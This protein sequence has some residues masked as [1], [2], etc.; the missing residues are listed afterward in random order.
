MPCVPSRQI[1]EF[2]LKKEKGEKERADAAAEAMELC[3][4]AEGQ[5]AVEGAQEWAAAKLGDDATEEGIEE[6]LD[7][8]NLMHELSR[9]IQRANAAERQAGGTL[10]DLEQDLARDDKRYKKDSNHFHAVVEAMGA[11]QRGI[12]LR[13][14]S[15][16]KLDRNTEANVQSRFK[17]YMSLKVGCGRWENHAPPRCLLPP[18]P[19]P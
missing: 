3:D 15:L 1:E 19:S 13:R 18:W 5:A 4:E 16:K 11:V 2:R 7:S 10:E 9:M 8:E 12:M 14:Q 17:H 6:L